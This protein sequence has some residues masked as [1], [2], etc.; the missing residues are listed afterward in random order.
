MKYHQKKVIQCELLSTEL[1]LFKFAI[2]KYSNL[3][4]VSNNTKTHFRFNKNNKQTLP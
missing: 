1:H 2:K 4:F 3:K